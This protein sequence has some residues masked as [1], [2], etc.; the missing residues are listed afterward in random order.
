MA[1]FIKVDVSIKSKKIK[2]I[3]QNKNYSHYRGKYNSLRKD[4]HPE[5]A[6]SII[7]NRRII[8]LRVNDTREH[9]NCIIACGKE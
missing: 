5:N 8:N 4:R 9:W 6:C 7:I 2:I 3:S 1:V